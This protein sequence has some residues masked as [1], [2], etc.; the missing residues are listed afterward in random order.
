MLKSKTTNPEILLSMLNK[1]IRI[2]GRY[3]EYLSMPNEI[4]ERIVN[5]LSKTE[6]SSFS[7]GKENLIAI[8]GL[9]GVGKTTLIKE[10]Y[11]LS[12]EDLAIDI[13]ECERLPVII[14][15]KDVSELKYFVYT[16][17]AE[18]AEVKKESLDKISATERMNEKRSND[19]YFEIHIPKD[20]SP[21]YDSG[22]SF[23]LLPGIKDIDNLDELNKRVLHCL[24]YS[25]NCIVCIDEL[26]IAGEQ[27]KRFVQN[28]VNKFFTN[29]K[30]I[31]AITHS[32]VIGLEASSKIKEKYQEMLGLSTLEHDRVICTG[33]SGKV[34]NEW[35]TEL[36][37]LIK[38]YTSSEAEY[39]GQQLSRLK[40]ALNEIKSIKISI[41]Y[42][43]KETIIDVPW[44][45]G[46][47]EKLLQS[48]TKTKKNILKGLSRELNKPINEIASKCEDEINEQLIGFG[49]LF[50]LMRTKFTR[51]IMLEQ[52]IQKIWKQHILESLKDI[53]NAI[54]KVE[55]DCYFIIGKKDNI[56]PTI[57][58]KLGYADDE[59]DSREKVSTD[60]HRKLV[61]TIAHYMGSLKDQDEKD[62]LEVQGALKLMP[63][64]MTEYV[65]LYFIG[66]NQNKPDITDNY[67]SNDKAI[68]EV[69]DSC[70]KD[71][72]Q[73][74]GNIK[75]V[76]GG[77]IA[78]LGI[79][80]F[81]DKNLNMFESLLA[82][83]GLKAAAA[84][85]WAGIL[86]GAMVAAVIFIP[87]VLSLRAAYSA[88][89]DTLSAYSKA[90]LDLL[91]QNC[92]QTIVQEF[93]TGFEIIE[94][95]IREQLRTDSGIP[96][97]L[98][99]AT[100]LSLRLNELI[101]LRADILYLLN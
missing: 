17:H 51:R 49:N 15:E 37:R 60:M 3:C 68:I 66:T 97:Q 96:E 81:P 88:N 38:E 41:D 32:D 100:N 33:I 79:D 61:Y 93:D 31:F 46:E 6:F 21:D 92:I 99:N 40:D 18:E 13:R 53:I 30:P 7:I 35:K 23:V 86:G 2:I 19:L 74:A 95:R 55:N 62:H 80:Y 83:V 78:M 75:S 10:Y 12:N 45:E 56:K 89:Q 28:Y 50:K 71:S 48:Y 98:D 27:N 87:T 70:S 59:G 26:T 5:L 47:L 67:F 90:Y 63:I 42:H 25:T 29:S 72:N 34:G 43:L 77:L 16:Y 57:V 8:T 54:E 11:G 24:V 52:D 73:L 82:G 94:E 4:T 36:S 85:K 84:M 9:Q 20:K 64:M 14:S 44:I 76:L 1:K 65:R 39:R 91:K 101:D 69:F 58:E 22:R